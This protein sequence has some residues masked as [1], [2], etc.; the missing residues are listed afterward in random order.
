MTRKG[1]VAQITKKRGL[2]TELVGVCLSLLF[3]LQLFVFGISASGSSIVRKLTNRVL[4]V[5]GA[6]ESSESIC[7]SPGPSTPFPPLTSTTTNPCLPGRKGPSVLGLQEIITS[8]RWY[9]HG[10]TNFGK[11]GPSWRPRPDSTLASC[12]V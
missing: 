8:Q 12:V 9:R 6:R 1:N 7:L 3:C 11:R 4:V 10:D 2:R 5:D